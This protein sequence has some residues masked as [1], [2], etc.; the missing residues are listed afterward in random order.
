VAEAHERMARESELSAIVED[1]NATGGGKD[2]R[3]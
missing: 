2:K 1:D 3:T